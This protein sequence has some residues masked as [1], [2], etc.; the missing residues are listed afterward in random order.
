LLYCATAKHHTSQ[1]IKTVFA[2]KKCYSK[3]RL[4]VVVLMQLTICQSSSYKSFDE[5]SICVKFE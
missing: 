4:K 1:L 2:F 3:L 5:L